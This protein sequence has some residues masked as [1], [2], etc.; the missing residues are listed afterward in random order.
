MKILFVIFWEKI[1]FGAI[2]LGAIKI[3]SDHCYDWIFKKL[4]HN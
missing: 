1:S 4:G 2:W 3:E